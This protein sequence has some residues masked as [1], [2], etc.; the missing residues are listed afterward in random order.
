MSQ[1]KQYLIDLFNRLLLQPSTDLNVIVGTSYY[2]NSMKASIVVN[3]VSN[4]F[5][6]SSKKDLLLPIRLLTATCL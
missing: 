4:P 6:V 3:A 2:S 1:L 5:L